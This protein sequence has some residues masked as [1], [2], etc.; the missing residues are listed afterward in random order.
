MDAWES[1][2]S[3]KW[4]HIRK[5]TPINALNKLMFSLFSQARAKNIPV[6]GPILQSK[7][8][9]FTDQL[10][11]E[12]FQASNGWLTSWKK[13]YNIKQFKFRV[14]EQMWIW[15]LSV[16]SKTGFQT[17]F[18]HTDQKMCLTVMRQSLCSELCL[19]KRWHRRIPVLKEVW[20][21]K[22][23]KLLLLVKQKIQRHSRVLTPLSCAGKLTAKHG[24]TQSFLLNG[25]KMPTR[26]W[27]CTKERFFC[28]R[29]MFP[30]MWPVM[31]HYLSQQIPRKPTAFRCWDYKD[32]QVSFQEVTSESCCGMNGWQQLC[33]RIG[34]EVE[35][36]AC[37]ELYCYKFKAG[38][39]ETIVK[40]FSRCSFIW[41]DQKGD[42][43]TP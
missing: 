7:A 24:W 27:R 33:N 35:C 12:D 22:S 39:E 40:C 4:Q 8:L 18:Q 43:S 13:R 42:V 14:K 34:A 20:V 10:D 2:R 30:A 21:E 37:S 9:Q 38:P 23:W 29:I 17:I 26:E 6:S 19:T 11:K 32:I 15:L 25:F 5:D 28:I 41:S 3:A 36:I 1:N 16:T 31:R